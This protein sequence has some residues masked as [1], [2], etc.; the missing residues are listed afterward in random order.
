MHLYADGSFTAVSL[1]MRPQFTADLF[2]VVVGFIATLFNS[3]SAPLE[4]LEGAS[5][6]RDFERWMKRALGAEHLSL[7]AV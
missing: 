3:Y 4:N 5:F 1:A 2:T 6:T 7:R